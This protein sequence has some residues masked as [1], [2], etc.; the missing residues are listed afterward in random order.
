MNTIFVIVGV[1]IMVVVAI[2]Y[3]FTIVVIKKRRREAGNQNMMGDVDDVVTSIGTKIIITVAIMNT[4]Y[5]AV[6]F[7]REWMVDRSVAETQ[8]WLAFAIFLT[9]II[10]FDNSIASAVIF[11]S[12]NKRAQQKLKQVF[13]MNTNEVQPAEMEVGTASIE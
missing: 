10:V 2:M 13:R 12:R 3:T 11:L 6:S 8:Q 4:P 1:C 5:F 7:I 9:Y